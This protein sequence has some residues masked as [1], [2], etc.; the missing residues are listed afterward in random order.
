MKLDA[1][2]STMRRSP[3]YAKRGFRSSSSSLKFDIDAMS[4]DR[5]W[6]LASRV[7]GNTLSFQ[8]DVFS[9]GFHFFA[10]FRKSSSVFQWSLIAVS[11]AFVRLMLVFGIF[12]IKPF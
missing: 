12:P 2:D 7:F 1:Q 6:K 9:F 11:P 5:Q 8:P 3:I 10:P 4:G